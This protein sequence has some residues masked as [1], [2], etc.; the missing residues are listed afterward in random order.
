M[1]EKKKT[2]KNTATKR[3][4]IRTRTWSNVSSDAKAVVNK[5]KQR[6]YNYYADS[7]NIVAILNKLNE[8]ALRE[9]QTLRARRSPPIDA[10]SPRWL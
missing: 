3:K 4:H 5:V 9:T 7:N 2:E 1:L 10:Q 8:K 6:N